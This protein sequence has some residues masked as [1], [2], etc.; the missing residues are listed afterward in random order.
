MIGAESRV[1]GA[2]I[3]DADGAGAE[4]P[5]GDTLAVA[6]TL[7]PPIGM[8]GFAGSD[9]GEDGAPTAVPVAGAT[10][11]P[12]PGRTEVSVSADRGEV[13]LDTPSGSAVS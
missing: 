13:R 1:S 9:C 7:P 11:L 12:G 3:A 10:A 6:A 8:L 2:D 4:T 5:V